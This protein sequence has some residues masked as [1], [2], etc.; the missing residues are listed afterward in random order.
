MIPEDSII[1][2]QLINDPGIF[3]HPV[4]II[5][6]ATKGVVEI[7]LVTTLAGQ[8]VT[9]KFD[10]SSTIRAKYLSIGGLGHDGTPVLRV[11]TD[12]PE[13][14]SYVCVEKTY[15]I[16]ARHLVEMCQ[17]G[18]NKDIC[19]T[20]QSLADMKAYKERVFRARSAKSWR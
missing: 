13:K 17:Q 12:A 6:T 16:E 4:M 15:R 18:G 1:H 19:L 3:S 8:S 5:D 14:N 9:T 11:Q 10:K 20:K 7:M 2:A